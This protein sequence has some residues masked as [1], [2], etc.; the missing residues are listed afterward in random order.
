MNTRPLTRPHLSGIKPEE[1]EMT[2][3]S[4]DFSSSEESKDEPL[5]PIN[6][7]VVVLRCPIDISES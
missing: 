1:E 6:A 7:S 5:L 4:W 2:M 3:R